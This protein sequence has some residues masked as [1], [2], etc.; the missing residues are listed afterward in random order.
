[1]ATLKDADAKTLLREA[2]LVRRFKASLY[3]SKSDKKEARRLLR[4]EE[5]KQ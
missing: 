1:M 4:D 5:P 3:L 2:E